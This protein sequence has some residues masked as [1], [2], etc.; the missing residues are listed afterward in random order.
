[1]GDYYALLGIS[2]GASMGEIRAAFR[3]LVKRLHPDVS[4][5]PSAAERFRR[6][7]EAYEVLSDPVRRAAYDAEYRA[8]SM[9]RGGATR[10]AGGTY[11][12]AGAYVGYGT[13]LPRDIQ[14][15][16]GASVPKGTAGAKEVRSAP[17]GTPRRAAR[18]SVRAAGAGPIAPIG[19]IGGVGPG[20]RA[21]RTA[22][23]GR[24]ETVRLRCVDCG[25]A[26]AEGAER[27][28]TCLSRYGSFQEHLASATERAARMRRRT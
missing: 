18:P 24:A 15:A 17:A 28:A 19:A 9:R 8:R 4:R 16:R 11:G 3:L 1:M 27:C 22:G 14:A 23:V 12:P 21:R 10:G 20:A 26:V 2:A 5:L 25:A 6:V 13:D 7:M